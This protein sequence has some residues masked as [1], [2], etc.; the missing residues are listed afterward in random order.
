M[1]AFPP[2]PAVAQ[3]RRFVL[4]NHLR[5]TILTTPEETDGRH[6][7]ADVTLPPGSDTPLHKHTRYEERLWVVEGTVSVWA[8]Q[9]AYTL[10]P[11]DF[12]TITMN[13][14]HMLE[15]GPEGVRVLAMSSPAHFVDLIRRAGTP[16][17]EAT[18]D[19]E[20]DLE[21]FNTITTELGDVILGPPGMRPAD[22]PDDN[23]A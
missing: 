23:P 18:T 10:G 9:D 4:G 13:T 11:G 5:M 2:P 7:L 8:G 22:L 1:T 3:D 12:Y 20:W 15:A 21:L 6:D 14:P 17:A 16:E 19:T